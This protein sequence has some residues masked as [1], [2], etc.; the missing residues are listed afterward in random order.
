MT[1]DLSGKVA[2][3]TG[4]SRGVG[5][6]T[7]AMLAQ[8]GAQVAITY[9]ERQSAAEEVLVR[10][11]EKRN[12]KSEKAIAIRADLSRREDCERVVQETVGAFGG[13]DI[14]VANAGVWPVDDIPVQELD[15]ER[16]RRT[17]GVN[18]DSVFF[19]CRAAVNVMRS[20]KRNVKSET[21]SGKIVI[22]S[23][24][25]AQRGESFHADY[26]ASKGAIN[27][28]VKSLAIEVAPDINVNA[29][30]PGWI[31]TEMS[32]VPYERDGGSG[33]RTIEQAIPMQ[34]IASAADVAGPIL[35]LCSDLARHITGEILNINGGAVLC[36]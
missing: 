14:F 31:D 1:I 19:G 35:F 10:I 13:L 9:R 11:G 20:E 29:V 21:G 8:V 24:T 25:A 27:S 32:R 16:W 7:A 22:V 30:A 26:A 23:S 28:F 4:G 3:V 6:A 15:E 36:G 18:L 12:V 17:L 2:L 34:R 33:R 5:A